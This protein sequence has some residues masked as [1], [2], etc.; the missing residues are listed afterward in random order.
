MDTLGII[1][2][3]ITGVIS[4]LIFT[5]LYDRYLAKQNIENCLE[6]LYTAIYSFNN[7]VD[8]NYYNTALIQ[9]DL[10]LKEIMELS[11][12]L[13]PF[14]F[15][16]KKILF[17]RTLLCNLYRTTEYLKTLEIGYDEEKEYKER[18]EKYKRKYLYK[19]S[20]EK[21]N[22]ITINILK[23]LCESNYFKNKLSLT[24]CSKETLENLIEINS[25]KTGKKS[26][27]KIYY[28]RGR[29]FTK[30]K[31]EEYINKVYNV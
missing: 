6:I 3:V 4:S 18:C 10:I 17:I 7:N 31:Y 26:A 30:T 15:N 23:D 12:N 29:S 5:I 25:F 2:G 27:D 28:L 9:T 16:Y 19:I 8:Y 13:S 24:R 1:I 21:F 11:K 14:V 20:D 22:V